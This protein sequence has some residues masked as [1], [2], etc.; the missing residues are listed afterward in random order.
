MEMQ[1]A[2]ERRGSRRAA[3]VEC[4]VV[5]EQGF[6]LVGT[7]AVDLSP[8]GML[9]STP[10]RATLGEEL[11]VAF[12]IPGTERWVDTV[13][14]IARVVL[15]RRWGDG[16]PALGL[17]FSPIDPEEHRLLRWALRRHPPT[18]P[19]R[20]MRVDYV[21][22]CALAEAHPLGKMKNPA[23]EMSMSSTMTASDEFTTAFVVAHPTPSDPPY[24]DSPECPDTTGIAAP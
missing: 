3:I 24:V 6:Q 16:G 14:T 22:T 2:S 20:A 7:R 12:R 15:G 1:L 11:L 19:C 5:R 17:S 8:D 9:L 13:G 10:V 23:P 21:A 18:F 4:Q